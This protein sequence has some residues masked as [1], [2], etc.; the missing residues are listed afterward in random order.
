M[1]QNMKDL[2]NKILL[3]LFCR[4]KSYV[5]NLFNSSPCTKSKWHSFYQLIFNDIFII[6]IASNSHLL[7]F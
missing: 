1:K 3:H 7:K 6:Y 2:I 5:Q 4:H